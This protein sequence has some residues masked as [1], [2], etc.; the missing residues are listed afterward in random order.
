MGSSQFS[1]CAFWILIR[2]S[3]WWGRFDLKKKKTNEISRS[4]FQIK[5]SSSYSRNQIVGK[6]KLQKLPTPKLLS[7]W[8]FLW[9]FLWWLLKFVNGFAVGISKLNINSLRFRLHN[10]IV[11]SRKFEK[12][13]FSPRIRHMNKWWDEKNFKL[14]WNIVLVF[15]SF[16]RVDSI[17]SLEAIV[18]IAFDTFLEESPWSTWIC[19]KLFNVDALKGFDVEE[20]LELMVF[21]H[22][23]DHK[24]FL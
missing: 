10:S 11:D 18:K 7:N 20:M 14:T 19:E 16:W 22:L 23:K 13:N 12:V 17:R 3:M 15:I 6:K 9:I 8:K 21:V 4:P 5:C 24:Q 2:I 1:L